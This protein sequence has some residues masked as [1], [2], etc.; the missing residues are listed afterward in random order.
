MNKFD[1]LK[2]QAATLQED[3]YITLLRYSNAID[4]LFT[5]SEECQ[6]AIIQH[7]GTTH[8]PLVYEAVQW[9]AQKQPVSASPPEQNKNA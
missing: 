7:F 8:S 1:I 6:K 5:H 4:R 3:V 9:M 2:Q